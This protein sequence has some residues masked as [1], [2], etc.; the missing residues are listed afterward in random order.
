VA[1]VCTKE[2]KDSVKGGK[3]GRKVW[4]NEKATKGKGTNEGK[5]AKA[6]GGYKVDHQVSVKG[7]REET[8]G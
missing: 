7:K 4:R 5:E 8:D 3:Q 6:D 2:N 1:C